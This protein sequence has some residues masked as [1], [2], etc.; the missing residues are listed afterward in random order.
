MAVLNSTILE[1]AWLSGS[2]DYQQRIPNPAISSYADHVAALFDPMNHDLFNQFSGLLNGL[3]GTYIESRLFENPL[4]VLKKPAAQ[5]GNTERRVAVKYLQA[6]SYKVDDETLLKLEK[7]E[8]VEWF[9]S[10]GEPRRY[11]FSWSKYELQRAFSA[12]GYGY[13]ELLQATITQAY[14]SDNYDEMNIMIQMFAEA[15]ERMGGLYRYNLSAAPTDET[16]AKELLK[17]IRA[18]AGRM[19]FPS[20]L[21]NHIP[22]PVHENGDT[23]VVWVTPEVMASLDVDALASVFQLDRA[24]IQYRIIQI[25][26]FPIPDVYAAITSEDFIYARDVWYGI[27]PPFYNPANLTLKYYLHHAQMI[28]VNP[29][30]NCVLFTTDENTTIPTITMTPSALEFVDDTVD[31]ELGGTVKLGIN[32]TGTLTEGENEYSGSI[33]VEPDSAMFEVAATRTTAGVG[34]DPDVTEA[35]PLNSRTYVDDYGVLHVQKSGLQVDDVI[36]VTATSTWINPSGETSTFSDTAEATVIT[37]VAQGAKECVVETDPYI[38]Y[39]DETV[40]ATASE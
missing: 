22:V 13:D 6:H 1:R 40:E 9:Y 5:W 17:G 34:D 7:P 19:R 33:A 38:T 18:V 4:A 36:T 25:P 16:T 29:A 8:F 3:M 39:T 35:V 32:L 28:G 30:A 2:N 26:E 14:S 23:L 24:N 12:D 31:V 21:Y 15:D 37:P 11:E 10:V 27:E 20:M